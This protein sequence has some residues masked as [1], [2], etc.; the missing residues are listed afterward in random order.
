[1]V[2]MVVRQDLLLGLV[3]TVN[4]LILLRYVQYNTA[5]SSTV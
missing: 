3:C 4:E 5:E 1:M 2:S